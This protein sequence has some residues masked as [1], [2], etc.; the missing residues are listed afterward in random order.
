MDDGELL[1]Q[2]IRRDATAW[3]ELFTRFGPV[4]ERTIRAT[5]AM[6]SYRRSD[7]DVRN[8]MA[9][10]FER[11][12]RD[13]FRALR[14][15]DAWHAR[16]PEKGFTDWLTIVT[17]NV[18]RNYVAGKLGSPDVN[19]TSVKQLVNTYAEAFV[20]D[21]RLVQLPHMTNK[22]TAQRILE[23]ARAHL[24]SDQLCAL[25]GWLEGKDFTELATQ[26]GWP[27]AR[28]ADRLVRAALAKLRRHFGE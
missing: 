2:V 9:S 7:D 14:T 1:R 8:V 20:E 4:V 15:F 28:D 6:G 26:F 22:E 25:E 21:D 12:R 16:N 24:T 27:D 11:L 19:G 18:A 17:V 3:M 5:R 23:F 10:V 13:D